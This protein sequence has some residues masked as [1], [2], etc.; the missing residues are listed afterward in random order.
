MKCRLFHTNHFGQICSEH[1][2]LCRK[3]TTA[4]I[5]FPFDSLEE[6][7]QHANNFIQRFPE[8]ECAIHSE[9]GS[10]HETIRNER[11]QA[12]Y[13]RRYCTRPTLDRIRDAA[14]VALFITSLVGNVVMAFLLLR[15]P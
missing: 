6:A 13:V 2:D 15:R 5:E 4:K 14:M 3:D 12:D 7:R 10:L 8:M 9:D 11:A 1:G